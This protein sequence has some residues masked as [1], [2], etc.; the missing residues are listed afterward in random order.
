MK[1]RSFV[2]NSVMAAGAT[3][4]FPAAGLQQPGI[5]GKSL[6][7]LRIYHIARGGNNKGLLEQYYTQALIPFFSRLGVKVGAFDDY[8]L[9]EPVKVY[10][11]IAYPSPAVYLAVQES[12]HTD[13]EIAEAANS[14]YSI[15]ASTPVYTRYE[16][17]LLEAFDRMP[18]V[19][20]PPHDRGLFEL[21]IYES[22]NEDAG[23]RKVM[24]FNNE[25]IDLFLKVGLQPVFF[26]K[27]LAGQYMPA[28]IYMVSLP[29]MAGRNPA[30]A[31]F[32]TSEEWAV[33]RAK[34]EYADIV[35]NIRRIFLTPISWS[36]I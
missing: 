23:R 4:A 16:T 20:I 26:G 10:T 30:W 35:S 29:D 12:L 7:E 33:M 22:P 9:E 11:L 13:P 2:R 31:K 27:I 6:Y 14:Y 18:T 32:N 25:E 19:V 17:F 24:M 28:L 1:R 3:M 36:Q 5:R 8:S 34:P 21:R 15:P